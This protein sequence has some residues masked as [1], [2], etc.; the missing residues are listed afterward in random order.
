MHWHNMLREV[1]DWL[2]LE[3]FK[4]RSCTD[5]TMESGHRHGLMAGL[6]DLIS[7]SNLNDTTIL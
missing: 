3:M 7:F 4:E 2:S 5:D 1:I 6:D